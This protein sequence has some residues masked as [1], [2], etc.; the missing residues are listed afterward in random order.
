MAGLFAIIL[1][2]ACILLILGLIQPKLA[3]YWGKHKNR[4][5]VGIIYGSLIAV[6]FIGIGIFA[7]PVEKKELPKEEEKQQVVD[8]QVQVSV[9]D[10]QEEPEQI[11]PEVEKLD[12]W[13]KII[14]SFD[15]GYSKKEIKEKM[16]LAMTLYGV[17]LT[18]EN[19]SRTA[20]SLISMRREYGFEE[21]EILNYAISLYTPKVKM[22]L[23]D[24]IGIATAA[25]VQG[26]K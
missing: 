8:Q 5:Q 14:I 20:S 21:M 25:L 15:G 18:D 22:T 3:L 10:K 17:D 12:V 19:Y 24:A 13:E 4:K 26:I 16:D 23:P 1:L 6:S 11:N 9:E 2:I 7:P